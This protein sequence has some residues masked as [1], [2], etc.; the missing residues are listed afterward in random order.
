MSFFLHND[1]TTK[2]YEKPFIPTKVSHAVAN[3][4]LLNE[5]PL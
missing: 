3:I 5:I 2:K 4:F 1:E